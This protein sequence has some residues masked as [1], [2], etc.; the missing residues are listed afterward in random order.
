MSV[1]PDEI[2]RRILE[3]GI[4]NSK[5]DYKD[6]CCISISCRR[7]SRLSGEDA[8]WSTLISL[9]FPQRTDGASRSMSLYSN[10]KTLYKSSFEK[11]KAR[12]LAA[13]R[14]A[15]L[16]LESQVSVYAKGLKDIRL[17]LMEESERMKAAVQELSNSEKVRQASVA[18][19]VW[20]PEI[21]RGKQKQIVEQCGV[22]VNSRI[23]ALKME[24]KLCK[25]QI[26]AL[27]KAYKDQQRRLDVSKEEL[28]SLKYH[29]LRD[30]K[31][32]GPR[33]DGCNIKRKKLK[34]C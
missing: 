31:L 7:L 23:A 2:W 16:R 13:H 1:L 10:S 25:Q 22:P 26:S 18:L 24:L 14:R 30:Y 17:R 6:L 5:L 27:E 21:I 12:K 29:P 8:L 28:S 9:D 15:L 32:T 3:M 19:N 4:E 34:G 20:Q 11:D 33:R